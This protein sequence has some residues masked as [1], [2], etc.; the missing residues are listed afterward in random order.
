M[1]FLR[2]LAVS[3]LSLLLFLSLS[4]FSLVFTLNQTILNPDLLVSQLN[5]LDL[6][7]LVEEVLVEQV[8]EE[9]EFM[10]EVLKD[11]AVE[12]EPWIKEQAGV[13]IYSSYDYLTGKSQSLSVVISLEPLRESLKNN[14]TQALLKSPPPELA[15]LPPDVVSQYMDEF[16][17]EIFKGIPP[18]F[19]LDESSLG[20]DGMAVVEQLREAIPYLQI[21]FSILI[22]FMVLLILLIFVLSRQI[23]STSRSLGVTFLTYGALSYAGI[24]VA[25]KFTPTAFTQLDLP[26]AI[27]EWLPQL[28]SDFSAPTETFSLGLAAVGVALIIISVLYGRKSSSQTEDHD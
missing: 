12:L 2:G 27:R 8:P 13:I 9:Q 19:E 22:G 21:S 3:L 6:S 11:T 7:L 16:Y 5:R 24:F 26:S 25:N 17:G 15:G 4:V 14:L 20:A 28:I 1:K 23:K 18:T 10:T